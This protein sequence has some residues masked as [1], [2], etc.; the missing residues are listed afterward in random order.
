[1]SPRFW[2]WLTVA[3][4]TLLALNVA[5]QVRHKLPDPDPVPTFP[6]ANTP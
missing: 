6:G 2:R 4:L 5:N 1:M 3:L